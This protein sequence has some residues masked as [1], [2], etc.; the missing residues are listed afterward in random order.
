MRILGPTILIAL[1]GAGAAY[2]D[3]S[4]V[5]DEHKAWASEHEEMTKDHAEWKAADERVRKAIEIL[6]NAQRTL[7]Q[8]ISAHDREMRQHA[9]AI[10]K[11]DEMIAKTQDGGKLAA[12]N[13]KHSLAKADHEKLL[14]AHKT[15][16]RHYGNVIDVVE[17]I[18]KLK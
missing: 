2:A 12:L 16:K 17:D 1:L 5:R 4:N 18:E 13:E 14:E 8:D 11:H 6:K 15:S 9:S 3:P 7:K 10:K